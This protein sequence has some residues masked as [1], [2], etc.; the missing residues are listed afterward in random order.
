MGNR[1][2]RIYN[3]PDESTII[4]F[5]AGAI[6]ENAEALPAFLAERDY[7]HRTYNRSEN[8]KDYAALVAVG[9]VSLY[10]VGIT[11][12]LQ[13]EHIGDLVTWC[14]TNVDPYHNSGFLIDN[15]QSRP[16]NADTNPHTDGK[17]IA[18]W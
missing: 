15:R 9:N 8:E 17:Y 13:E 6:P 18:E 14:R 5:S 10:C 2:V 7:T 11:P 12:P 16:Y 4:G 1:K 3:G